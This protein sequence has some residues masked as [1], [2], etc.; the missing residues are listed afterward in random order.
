MVLYFFI[1]S[2]RLLNHHQKVEKLHLRTTR[3]AMF[4]NSWITVP[5][6]LPLIIPLRLMGRRCRS[7]EPQHLQLHL[8]AMEHST[9]TAFTETT[10]PSSILTYPRECTRRRSWVRRARRISVRWWGAGVVGQ[11][12][13]VHKDL[14][15]ITKGVTISNLRLAGTSKTLHLGSTL[16]GYSRSTSSPST[17]RVVTHPRQGR[18]VRGS[19]STTT[20]SSSSLSN[21]TAKRGTTRGTRNR[22][23][24]SPRHPRGTSNPHPS[25]HSSS[26]DRTPSSSNS[27]ASTR[28]PIIR[29]TTLQ[30]PLLQVCDPLA[31]LREPLQ[32]RP[33]SHRAATAPQGHTMSTTSNRTRSKIIT[34]IMRPLVA[35]I[36]TPHGAV[37]RGIPLHNKDRINRQQ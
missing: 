15:T 5:T 18:T 29:G 10:S 13:V 37:R 30:G 9:E 3:V 31:P 27:T 34:T 4:T 25:R 7:E 11:V 16:P 1:F 17:H 8:L 24:G 35:M 28:I 6:P 14:R 2:Q 20:S 21:P 32:D 23:R 33:P 12:G 22:G 36:T 19:L 26:M